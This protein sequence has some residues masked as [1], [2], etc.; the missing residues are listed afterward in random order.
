MES[1]DNEARTINSDSPVD[2]RAPGRAPAQP[3]EVPTGHRGSAPVSPI[4]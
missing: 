4:C 3:Y 1:D 2:C